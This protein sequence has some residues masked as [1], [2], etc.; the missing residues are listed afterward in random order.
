MTT[1]YFFDQSKMH[2]FHHAVAQT[3]QGVYSQFERNLEVF[4]P[5]GISTFAACAGGAVVDSYR[6]RRPRDFDFM[7]LEDPKTA[8]E[9][10]YSGAEEGV[11]VISVPFIPDPVNPD[12]DIEAYAKKASTFDISVCQIVVLPGRGVLATAEALTD[13]NLGVCRTTRPTPAA[14]VQKYVRKGMADVRWDHDIVP[15]SA[16]RRTRVGLD[17]KPK[18]VR[19]VRWTENVV[20]QWT[21]P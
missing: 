15:E 3:A 14:R 7:V 20:P 16:D 1:F 9:K 12:A 8:A 18:D 10:D 5:L 19:V 2:Q 17:V 6:G 11:D 21:A 13:L 4:G